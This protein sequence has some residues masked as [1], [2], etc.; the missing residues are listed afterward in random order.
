L[1]LAD[2]SRLRILE[3]NAQRA[4]H[5]ADLGAMAAGIAHEV[6]N[7]LTSLRGCAQEL[8]EIT[9]S[10]GQADAAALATIMIGEADRLAR[11]VN[12][13][14]AM[15]RLRAPE[16]GSVDLDLLFAET[17][18][19]A[20]ARSDLPLGISLVAQV[21]DECPLAH[22]DEGQLR[23]IVSNLINNALDAVLHVQGP[24]IT[25]RA[26][27]APA[28][29]PLGAPAVV[30]EVT[31]NGCGIPVELQERV[32]TPFFSTKAQGTGLG[33]SLVSRIV[34]EHEG[35]L[36]LDSMPGHGTTIRVLLPARSQTREYRRALG[37]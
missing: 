29:N 27:P 15:S 4:A 19:L 22:A 9:G 8:A 18:R 20:R 6:R 13:F 25:C 14:L 30:I 11:I 36:S 37:R 26:G 17:M 3:E 34:R 31:D 28:G 21:A 2:E 12:D 5:L 7:P 23:Q 33:L 32:F 24:A 10:A 16:L 1:L 35:L